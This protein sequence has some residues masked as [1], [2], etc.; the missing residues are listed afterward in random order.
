MPI[1]T[2]FY[3]CTDV[4]YTYIFM[5]WVHWII[6]NSH[7]HKSSSWHSKKVSQIVYSTFKKIGNPG[8]SFNVFS[9]WGSLFHI[10]LNAK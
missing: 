10:L 4:V 8:F 9:P 1:C 3:G 7:T 5:N 6:V 2:I